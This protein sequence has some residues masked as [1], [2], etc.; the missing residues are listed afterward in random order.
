MRG[1]PP[2]LQPVEVE[3]EIHTEDGA[4]LRANALPPAPGR[5]PL[6]TCVLAHAMFARRTEFTRPEGQSLADLLQDLGFGVVAFDFRGH[7]DS[8]GKGRQWTYDDLV[9]RDLRAVIECA[10]AREPGRLVVIGHSLGGHAALAAQGL[11]LLGADAIVC[12]AANVW[13]RE[14][15]PSALRWAAKRAVSAVVDGVVAHL[16]RV[17][18]RRLGLGSDDEASDYMRAIVA[19]GAPAA[20]RALAGED[21]LE[22]V[23][24]VTVPVAQ[25]TSDGD[26]L[27]CHPGSGEA[28]ARRAGGPVHLER[29]RASGGAPAPDHMQIVTRAGRD[30]SVRAAWERTLAW[31]VERTG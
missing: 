18:A 15:E 29:L 6:G 2:P 23:G 17:P 20:G 7:G 12:A 27:N 26:R 9:K 13:M 31:V 3:I 1:R 25:I 19:P 4:A 5:A 28:F 30:P 8:S 10:R 21:Y 11:G 24:R 14:L 16:G 22:A